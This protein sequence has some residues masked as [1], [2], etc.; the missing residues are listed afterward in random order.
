MW[1]ILFKSPFRKGGLPCSQLFLSPFLKGSVIL[2]LL[3][4]FFVK[5]FIIL[6][7]VNINLN[8]LGVD[9]LDLKEYFCIN[10]Q[11]SQ[12]GLKNNGNIVK[13]GTY[14][15]H[16][17]QMLQCKVCKQRFSETRNT[18]FFGTKYSP[19]TIKAIIICIA[20]GNGIRRTARILSLSKDAVNKIVKKAGEHCDLVLSNLLS[21]LSLEQC[22]MDELWSFVRK[23]NRI[24]KSTVSNGADES[25]SG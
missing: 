10:E 6:E 22:Q 25:G 2:S 19:E 14:G 13:C 12:Y 9:M 8:F 21:S 24:P 1:I 23:K 5:F 16:K 3:F 20:E 18:A 17:R 11:C 4:L 15:K 7:C